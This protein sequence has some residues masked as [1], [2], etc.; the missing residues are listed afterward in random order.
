MFVFKKGGAYYIFK[1]AQYL[2][3]KK[4]LK[5]DTFCIYWFLIKLQNVIV[6]AS[7]GAYNQEGHFFLFTGRWAYELGESL[8]AVVYGSLYIQVLGKAQRKK[9]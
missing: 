4:C 3:Q 7:G 8:K 1:G 6:G 9:N 2:E 5:Q